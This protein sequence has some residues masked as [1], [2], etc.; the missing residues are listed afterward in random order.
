MT[1]H[2]DGDEQ[3]PGGRCVQWYVWDWSTGTWQLYHTAYLVVDADG[4]E[5]PAYERGVS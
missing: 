2:R 3:W 1:E 4:R 5:H